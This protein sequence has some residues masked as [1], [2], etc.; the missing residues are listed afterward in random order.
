MRHGAVRAAPMM[1][2]ADYFYRS[3]LKADTQKT[4]VP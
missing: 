3:W 1:Y 2:G 4:Q